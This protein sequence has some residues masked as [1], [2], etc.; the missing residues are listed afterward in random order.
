MLRASIFVATTLLAGCPSKQPEAPRPVAAADSGLRI[1]IAQAEV[2]RG[3]GLAE[4]RELATSTDPHARELALRGLGRSGLAEA[5]P[6]LLAALADPEPRVVIAAATAIGVL[7]SLDE[8]AKIRTSA[9]GPLVLQESDKAVQA[10][11]AEALGRAGAMED[12]QHLVRCAWTVPACALAL[13]RYGRRKLPLQRGDDA[14]PALI[15]ASAAADPALRYA[16]T[17][18]LSRE[19]EPP[20]EDAAATIAALIARIADAQPET[21]AVAIAGLAKRKAVAGAARAP[22]EAAFRDPDWRVAVEAARA[23]A[24]VDDAGRT[25]VAT[26]L[27]GRPPHVIH[28]ALR[29]FAGKPLEPAAVAALTPLVHEPGWTGCLAAAALGGNPNPPNAG[30]P[31]VVDAITKCQ[32]A[33][34]L[35]LG[36]LAEVTDPAAKRA[37]LR[38]M[39]AHDD[40]RVRGAGI[41]L[42][43]STWKDADARAQQTIVTTLTSSLA[44]KN[45]IV[46]GSAADAISTIL[47]GTVDDAYKSSLGAAII[48]RAETET[49]VELSASLL[50]VIEKRTITAGLEA[51]RRS[52]GTHVVRDKAARKCLLALGEAP[53]SA[54]PG[55]P[56]PPVDVATVIGHKVTWRLATTRG[57]ITIELRPDVAPWAVASIVAITGRKGYDG[58]EMHRV[59]PNFVAQGGDPTSSG[60]GG[61]GYMLPA[62]SSGAADGAGFVQGGVGMADSGPDSAGSQWF[63]MHSRAAHLDGRYTWIGRVTAGMQVVDA[64]VIGDKVERATVMVE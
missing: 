37:A 33:D 8:T 47:E 14:R 7:A 60:W 62:E 12:A 49:D 13:G 34:H 19:H 25:L 11:A 26:S 16:A 63:I 53:A 10:A 43:A 61:P 45:P 28:E 54:S 2:R 32:L 29:S 48:S 50:G 55:P 20:P 38:V 57:D 59:V 35:K 15:D 44:V 27:V 17:Y 4:L 30:G 56:G 3:A 23:L 22:I 5:I 18:A 40:P 31:T 41:G 58:L 24:A 9:L 1:R 6:T 21:R 51:C 52:I 36:L 46:A 42:L 39:L 64:L